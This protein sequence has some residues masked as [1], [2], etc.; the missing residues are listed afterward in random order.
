MRSA[1]YKNHNSA[2]STFRITEPCK[3]LNLDLSPR[4]NLESI[5]AA[6][7]KI[8]T[9]VHQHTEKCSVQEP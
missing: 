5:E 1:V 4:H 2:F 6:Y 7:F 9:Q 3:V 8:H